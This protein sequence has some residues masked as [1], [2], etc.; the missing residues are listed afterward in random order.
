[1]ARP[2][3]PRGEDSVFSTERRSTGRLG[4]GGAWGFRLRLILAAGLLSGCEPRWD[5]LPPPSASNDLVA[6]TH[7]GSTTF[8][9]DAEGKYAGLEYD[10]VRLFAEYL[11]VKAKFVILSRSDQVLPVL[12]EGK[13]HLAAAGLPI[14]PDP[15][16]RLDFG[17]PYQTVRVQLVYQA[18][19][20]GPKPNSVAELAGKR[21]AVAAGSGAIAVLSE[22]KR[23]VPD[24]TW[25]TIPVANSEAIFQRL[26]DGQADYVVAYSHEV[27]V[28][29]NFHPGLSVAFDL[30]KA[31]P[32]AWAFAKRGDSALPRQSREF[33]RSIQQNG[34]LRRLSDQ[35]YGHIKRLDQAGV[36]YFLTRMRTVLP[37]FKGLFQE[38]QE[39]TGIDWR[40]LA[41]VSFQESHWEPLATSPAGVR[42]LMM[43]TTDTADR[44]GVTDRLDPRQ[45][46]LA[47][48]RYFAAIRDGLP[49]RVPE[50]DRTWMAVAAYNVGLAHLEDARVLAQ[51]L[52]LNPNAWTD[53]KSTLPLLAKSEY[54]TTLKHGFA[55]GGEPVIMTENIRTYYDILVRYEPP[56]QPVFGS[57]E[58]GWDLGEPRSSGLGLKARRD[59]VK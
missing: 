23:T 4:V 38:A 18:D 26:L 28:A 9:Q 15:D 46:I 31:L 33:F 27:D 1:M 40:F 34:V 5:A 41:A 6:V 59:A 7:T 25:S 57:S 51:R 36:S 55:R 58:R 50:P 17:E 52:K 56:H 13:A 44:M 37:R 53:L 47:G 48:A 3:S 19:G 12:L 21:I 32:L 20:E 24:L 42:G 54:F 8:Y 35:Y 29:R 39:I 2:A 43:L 30:G 16:P 14:T 11:G 10:L 22:A 45:S 49:E